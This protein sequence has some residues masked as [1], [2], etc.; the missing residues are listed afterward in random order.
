MAFNF[1]DNSKDAITRRRPT[2]SMSNVEAHSVGVKSIFNV[3]RLTRTTFL[4]PS[5]C[6]SGRSMLKVRCRNKNQLRLRFRVAQKVSLRVKYSNTPSDSDLTSITKVTGGSGIRTSDIFGVN[7][8]W[9]FTNYFDGKN[10]KRNSVRSIG[11]NN[12]HKNKP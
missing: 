10:S 8:L 11:W 5:S 3:I 7:S 9:K 2:G 1:E 6:T 4:W 12:P